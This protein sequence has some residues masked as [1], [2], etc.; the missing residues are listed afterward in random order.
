MGFPKQEYWNGLPLPP[1]GDLP[2]PGIEPES[3][4]FPALQ[5][6]SLPREALGKPLQKYEKL[7][8]YCPLT[9]FNLKQYLYLASLLAQMVKNRP[10]MPEI[11]VLSLDREDSPGGEMATHSNI[12][13]WEI[14]R[15]EE[16]GGLY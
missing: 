16:P 14:P 6:D 11:W 5:A 9:F 2:N 8:I 4:V 10:V 7:Y 12:L 15:T 1:P 3:P 13:A